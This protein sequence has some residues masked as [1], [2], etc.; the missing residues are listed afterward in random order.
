M[1]QVLDSATDF[2]FSWVG[3]AILAVVVAIVALV[4]WRRWR[5]WN[6]VMGSSPES[7][8][9]QSELWATRNMNGPGGL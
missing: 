9:A 4:L 6:P 2:M 3:F 1:T 8:R 5:R 7:R